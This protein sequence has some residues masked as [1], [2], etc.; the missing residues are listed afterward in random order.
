MSL[1]LELWMPMGPLLWR[2]SLYALLCWDRRSLAGI[3]LASVFLVSWSCK[4]GTE[5]GVERE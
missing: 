3:L 4:R 5:M 2:R 1:E